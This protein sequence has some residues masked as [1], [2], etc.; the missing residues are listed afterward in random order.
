MEPFSTSPQ[1]NARKNRP[2][3]TRSQS[4]VCRKI[5]AFEEIFSLHKHEKSAR[6]VAAFLDVPNSTMQSW[7]SRKTTQELPPEVTDFISTLAGKEFLQR[8]FMSVYQVTHFGAG[9]IRGMQEFLELSMLDRF[10]ASSYGALQKF[11][12]RS[13]EYIVAFGE[14]EEKRLAEKMNK[15]KITAGLDELFRGKRPCLVAI[16]VVSNF[17]LLEKFT[18]D[19]KTATWGNEL[20]P[21]TDG[22]NVELGQVVSDLCG[23]I[24]AC[25]KELGATH[26]PEV[27][28]AQYEITKA[29]AGALASQER[30]F[31]KL[32]SEAEEKVEKVV[33]KHGNESEKAK[34]AMQVLGLRKFGLERRQERCKKVKDAKK[35][36]GRIHHPIDLSTGKLQTAEIMKEKFDAQTKIIDTTAK[37]ACLSASCLKRLEKAKRAFD[38]IV[39]YLKIFFVFYKAFVEGLGL[40]T[41]QERFFNE[42][43]FPLSYIKMVWRRLPKREREKLK[44]LKESLEIRLSVSLWSEEFK[45]EWMKKGQECAERFQ[46]SSSCVEGRNGVLSLYHHRFHRMSHRSLKALTVVHNFHTRRLDTSTAAERFFGTVHRNLFESLLANVQIP[47]RPQ[48][49]HHDLNKRQLGWAKRFIA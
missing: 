33:K 34:E 24:R 11:S 13:E 18:E 6:E 8:I 9:G 42:V 17:I 45:K 41:E 1:E 32:V 47:G 14:Q 21:R 31:E 10:I 15:R 2:K 12:V 35:E 46:R 43:I 49:Q 30:E 38:A 40:N 48:Q 28:H 44:R 39:E 27:F 5:I 29:T 4:E 3:I 19:R 7:M 36:L 37:E 20:K 25:A 22:L 26:I 23:G 16:D